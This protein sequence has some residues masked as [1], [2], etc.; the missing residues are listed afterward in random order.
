MIFEIADLEIENLGRFPLKI[1][2]CSNFYQIWYLVQ[3]MNIVNE[4]ANYE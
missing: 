1:A 3:I 2:M 4:H